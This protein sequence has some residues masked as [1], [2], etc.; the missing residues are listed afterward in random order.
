M[1]AIEAMFASLFSEL[2]NRSDLAAPLIHTS[3]FGLDGSSDTTGLGQTFLIWRSPIDG[4]AYATDTFVYNSA[5]KILRQNIV[6]MKKEPCSALATTT[7]STGASV[8][9]DKAARL[10]Q[11]QT[12]FAL[13][14]M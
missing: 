13:L 8:D 4:Y 5:G 6:A 7:N 11:R 14:A 2:A 10:W 12:I 9:V 1:T 3:T